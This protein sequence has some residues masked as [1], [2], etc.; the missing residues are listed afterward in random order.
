MLLLCSKVGREAAL[1]ERTR[2]P[3][4]L[5]RSPQRLM[6][7]IIFASLRNIWR[8]LRTSLQ[9]AAVSVHCELT[10]A[11]QQHYKLSHKRDKR[12]WRPVGLLRAQA[13]LFAPRCKTSSTGTA[14][15]HPSQER[16]QPQPKRLRRRLVASAIAPLLRRYRC[17]MQRQPQH[18]S[19]RTQQRQPT[20]R[21]AQLLKLALHHRL[22]I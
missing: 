9:L 6:R 19:A 16:T 12:R 20:L 7:A 17:L 3:G 11:L 10:R 2:R 13:L 4:L 14:L 21:L 1:W 15:L 18:N 22:R 8:T 5:Q